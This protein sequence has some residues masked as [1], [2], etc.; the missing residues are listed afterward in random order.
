MCLV[1]FLYTLYIIFV[2]HSKKFAF[3]LIF[4]KIMNILREIH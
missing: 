2:Y 1:L 3:L 4:A